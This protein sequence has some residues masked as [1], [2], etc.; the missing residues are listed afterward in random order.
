MIMAL[1]IIIMPDKN[2]IQILRKQIQCN[3][4][5][6]FRNLDIWK[7]GLETIR[8]SHTIRKKNRLSIRTKGSRQKTLRI[9]G[10][11]LLG[12]WRRTLSRK[13]L[14]T[15]PY[16]QVEIR[17]RWIHNMY[18]MIYLGVT[19]D[20]CVPSICHVWNP[21]FLKQRPRNGRPSQSIWYSAMRI[22]NIYQLDIDTRI[23]AISKYENHYLL[24]LNIEQDAWE[25]QMR[26]MIQMIL[27]TSTNTSIFPLKM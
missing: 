21:Q 9:R 18:Y 20:W 12:R 8:M 22:N 14:E 5:N 23:W 16:Q 2:F 15:W 24:K 3:T 26:K 7:H 6:A 4:N 27:L 10:S 25:Q 19:D 11:F 13:E 17:S 1:W